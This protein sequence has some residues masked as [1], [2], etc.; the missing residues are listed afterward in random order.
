MSLDLINLFF[1]I[2]DQFEVRFENKAK[3]FLSLSTFLDLEGQAERLQLKFPFQ[4][5][6]IL[7]DVSF[8]GNWF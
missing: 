3:Y 5:Q 1:E 7:C 2:T 6:W 8:K 4:R